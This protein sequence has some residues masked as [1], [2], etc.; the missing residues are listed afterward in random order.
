MRK[1]IVYGL[2]SSILAIMTVGLMSCNNETSDSEGVGNELLGNEIDDDAGNKADGIGTLIRFLS[3]PL[4]VKGFQVWVDD[5]E[6][7]T[8]GSS[9]YFDIR[10]SA[11]PHWWE[12]KVKGTT[13]VQR[14]IINVPVPPR[15]NVGYYK[16]F[17]VKEPTVPTG[18]T[19][20]YLSSDVI[21]GWDDFQVSIKG[22][23]TIRSMDNSAP[24]PSNIK[25]RPDYVADTDNRDGK[26]VVEL[27]AG[28]YDI[29]IGN[30]GDLCAG[31]DE[32]EVLPNV[33]N[34]PTLKTMYDCSYEF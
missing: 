7:G 21:A 8:A 24:D 29:R 3:S 32:F 4:Y 22:P 11:G 18:P 33:T 6:R 31:I 16:K 17:E 1:G 25:G 26:F 27:P 30:D 20:I 14:S 13:V 12:I 10:L 5:V 2:F 19:K 28:T 23:K 9:G 15:P 34:K